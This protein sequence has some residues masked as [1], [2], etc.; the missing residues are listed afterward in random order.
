MTCSRPRPYS[1]GWREVLMVASPTRGVGLT[2]SRLRSYS[3][4]WRDM[5]V[6]ASLFA[7]L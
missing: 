4:G 6:A 7:G 3:R 2:R 1:W 5:L